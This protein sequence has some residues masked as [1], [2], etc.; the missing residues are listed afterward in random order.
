M[1]LAAALNNALSLHQAGRLAEAQALYDQ[2]LLAAPRHPDTLQLRGTIALQQDRYAEALGYFDQAL[3]VKPD[4][5]AAHAN[6]AAAL[7]ALGHFDAALASCDLA[8]TANPASANGWSNRAAILN[9]LERYGK[10]LAAADRALGLDSRH[11]AA[12]RERIQ[13][14]R[15]VGQLE[16]AL[17]ACGQS[18]ALGPQPD[19]YSDRAAILVQL[20]RY[21]EAVTACDLAIARAPALAAAHG[22]RANA[23]T[24]LQRFEDAIAAYDRALALEPGSAEVHCNRAIAL[25]EMRRWQDALASVDAA[26]ELRPNYADAFAVRALALRGLERYEDAIAACDQALALDAGQIDA[27]LVRGFSREAL[28]R[29]EAALADFEAVAAARPDTPLIHG[30]HLLSSLQICRWDDLAEKTAACLA[31]VDAGGNGVGPFAV[32]ALPVTPQQQQMAAARYFADIAPPNALDSPDIYKWPRSRA[33]KIQLGYFS[34]DFFDHAT[35]RLA[36]GLFEGHDRTQFEVTAFA[37]GNGAPGDPMRARLARAFDHMIDVTAMTPKAIADLA[38]A[39]GIHIAIDLKGF[40]KNSRPAIFGLGA[41]PIQVSYL[42]YPGTLG[43]NRYDYV[44]GD[45]F[46][47]PVAHA[48]WFSENIVTLPNSYQVNDARRLTS[49]RVF[50]RRELGL[51]DRG[52]VFASFNNT[53]KITPRVFDIW[54]RLLARAEGSVLWQLEDNPVA[55][56]NLRA[57]AQKRGIDPTRLVFAPRIAVPEH[58]ARQKAADLF[59]DSFPCNAHTTA[60]DALWAGLPVVTRLADTFAGRVAASVLAAAGLP[61][62]IAESD[63]DYEAIALRLAQNPA[64]LAGY[65]KRLEDGRATCA[66]FDTARF[67]RDLEAAYR[68]MWATYEAG[69]PPAPFAVK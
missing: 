67:T 66:L 52:F 48:P 55:A 24:R 6:R 41:A 47:T 17:A 26:L 61:E 44:I 16:D 60:S 50:S 21:G 23:L 51:P 28:A 68:Q 46:V 10:A 36:A 57:E 34:T 18:L 54:M 49:P 3:A 37:F 58:V 11:M 32:V 33:C 65:R 63:R 64:E 29:Y 42:G 22:V 30:A 4:F 56:R 35:S 7:L 15:G 59:L 8:L 62:L 5:A 31:N 20:G 25:S 43:S 69:Q 40:T 9:K 13:A 27:R 12:H 53:F 14:L 39:R 2:I 45:R 19:I 1:D 38:R